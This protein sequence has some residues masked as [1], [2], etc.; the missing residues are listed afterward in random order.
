MEIYPPPRFRASFFCGFDAQ[1]AFRITNINFLRSA[2]GSHRS[3]EKAAVTTAQFDRNEL[4]SMFTH[5]DWRQA[6]FIFSGAP[7]AFRGVQTV[8]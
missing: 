8:F 5:T 4:K 2:S 1:T 6:A 7:T 3:M